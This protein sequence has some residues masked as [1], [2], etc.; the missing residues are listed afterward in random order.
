MSDFVKIKKE[1]LKRASNF[2]PAGYYEEVMSYKKEE[3][4]DFI[5]ITKE[6]MDILTNKYRL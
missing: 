4:N 1:I 2:R 5:Y 3:D 6:D